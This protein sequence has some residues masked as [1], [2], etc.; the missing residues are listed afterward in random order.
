MQFRDPKTQNTQAIDILH[1]TNPHI[2]LNTKHHL[3]FPTTVKLRKIGRTK[4]QN[5]ESIDVT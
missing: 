3:I 2:N 1:Y 4:L 5:I